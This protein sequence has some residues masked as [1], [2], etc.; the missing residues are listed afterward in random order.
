[1]LLLLFG[2][3]FFFHFLYTHSQGVGIWT[4]IPVMMLGIAENYC[5]NTY[6]SLLIRVQPVLALRGGGVPN[7]PPPI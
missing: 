7:L 3:G 6:F 2:V 1:M 5:R 4:L